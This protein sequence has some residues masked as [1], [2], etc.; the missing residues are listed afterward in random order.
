MQH[1]YVEKQKTFLRET[2]EYLVSRVFYHVH[3]T[4]HSVVLR[5]YFYQ[6]ELWILYNPKPY[7]PKPY[8]PKPTDSFIQVD[9][10]MHMKTG[11]RIR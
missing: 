9:F 5:C 6:I 3:K 1:F 10:K 4:K 7:H 2:K 11:P 8:N